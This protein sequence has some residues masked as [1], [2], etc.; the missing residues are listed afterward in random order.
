MLELDVKAS[1]NISLMRIIKKVFNGK[2]VE[3]CPATKLA[4]R[5]ENKIN[6]MTNTQR[7]FAKFTVP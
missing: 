3:L 6:N 4:S 5:N 7:L 2:T 1:Q